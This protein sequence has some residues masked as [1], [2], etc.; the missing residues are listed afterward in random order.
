[1]QKISTPL[2]VSAVALLDS[3][4]KIFMQQRNLASVHGGLWEFPGGKL[5]PGET[6]DVA[7]ARELAEE[8]G[9][10]LRAADLIPVGFAAD[11]GKDSVNGRPVVI[12]LY[13]CLRWQGVPNGHEAEAFGWFESSAIPKLPMPPLDYPL[14]AQ[15]HRALV[16]NLL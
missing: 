16:H 3:A 4:R 13:A 2:V 7:G 5:E 1:M 12:L 14:A 8:L 15:L 9:I 6:P 10:A 11:S